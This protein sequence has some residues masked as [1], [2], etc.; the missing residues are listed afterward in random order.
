MASTR[1]LK[2]DTN[3]RLRPISIKLKN[4]SSKDI[5]EIQ[6][7]VSVDFQKYLFICKIIIDD[8]SLICNFAFTAANATIYK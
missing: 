7:K 2:G 4:L 3:V 6:N 8:S 1:K 5:E